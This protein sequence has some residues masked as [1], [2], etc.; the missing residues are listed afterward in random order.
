MYYN[1][2]TY[3]IY[4]EKYGCGEKTILILP[5]WGNT[6]E[7]FY[8]IIS[9]FK[10]HY[11]IYILDYPGF[12]KSIFPENDLTIYDYANIIRDF[13]KAE[14][15][16]NPIIIAHSFGGRIAT[17][18]SAYYKDPV[19]RLVLID[20]AGIKHR[21]NMIQFIKSIIYKLL[22][23]LKRFIPKRKQSLYLKRLINLFGSADYKALS[24][25]MQTSFKNVV[26][27]DLKYYIQYIECKTLIIWG[28]KDKET[29]VSDAK[30]MRKHIKNSSLVIYP[31]ASHFSYLNQPNLTNQLIENFIKNTD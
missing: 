12:G 13:M 26:N 20:I 30:Y 31:G 27:E 29:K 4:Y 28:S 10:K 21:K 15:I 7:T 24:Q 2:D 18:I 9:Y 14:K 22:K 11:T 8:Q 25:N 23:K 1:K 16:I 3:S 17:L 5:G 19:D 6:R